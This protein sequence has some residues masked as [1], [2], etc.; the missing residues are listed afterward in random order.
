MDHNTRV[1]VSLTTVV[2]ALLV[3][4]S[5]QGQSLDTRIARAQGTVRFS[6]QPK[7][8]VCGDGA[9][10]IYIQN[11]RGGQRVQ[12]SGNSWNYSSRYSDEWAPVCQDGPARIALSVDRGR[13]TSLR[14]YVGGEWR[15]RD[16]VTDLG[17]LD[18]SE[19][20]GYL[21]S[22]AERATSSVSRDAMFA[23]TLADA[24]IWRRFLRIANN[25][26]LPR[27]IRK[28]AIFWLGQEAAEA[29]TAGLQN[30]IESQDEIEIREHAI[31]SISQ[32]PNSESVPALITLAR[33]HDIDPRLKK[34]ALF[35]LAQKDDP[36]A[37]ALFEQILIR[38]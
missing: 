32:R 34:R 17:R 2:A 28:Q 5:A 27:D 19:A 10:T 15:A 3:A 37:L 38:N 13:V 14:S 1:A 24:D 35:W 4:S 30:L 8:G 16:D 21:L 22:L 29:A 12:V 33:R 18:A 26:T 9:A 23:A 20:A 36:R 11:G 31:F 25:T 7:P 6:F